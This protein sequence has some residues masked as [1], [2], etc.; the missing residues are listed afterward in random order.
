MS[1]KDALL[2]LHAKLVAQRSEL[3]HQIEDDLGL[4]YS[5]DDGSNDLGEA[6]NFVEQTELHT[7]LAALES[8]EL[9]KI[10]LAI[11]QIRH[12]KY[13]ICEGCQKPIPIAR[14]Q[15]LPFTLCCVDCQRHQEDDGNAD[16]H[17]APNW[18]HVLEYERRNN[19]H[20]YSLGDFEL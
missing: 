2:K 5:D 18:G 4:A 10:D 15:M 17:D 9:E 14:L 7:Q 16:N 8:R 20:E 3:Q 11:L 1:R 6:S 13:G 12:G 19:Q